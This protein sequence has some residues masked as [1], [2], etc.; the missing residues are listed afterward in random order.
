V[1]IGK[2][3]ENGLNI[4]YFSRNVKRFNIIDNVIKGF[5]F[6]LFLTQIT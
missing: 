5:H 3:I 6:K 1:L 4:F 2:L